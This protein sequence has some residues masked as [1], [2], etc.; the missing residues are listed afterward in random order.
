MNK[1]VNQMDDKYRSRKFGLAVFF[2]ITD[3]IALF[4]DVDVGLFGAYIGAQA[5]IL[6]LY[7]MANVA[8]K[9]NAK[10]SES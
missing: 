5:T 8:E 6:G 4:S 10:S 3:T 2:T 1:V 9:R 7:G